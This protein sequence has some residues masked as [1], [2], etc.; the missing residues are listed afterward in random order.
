M[1]DQPA[2]EYALIWTYEIRTA[3]TGRFQK[4]YGP[5][6]SW[7]QLFQ[8]APGFLGTQLLQDESQENRYVTIDRWTSKAAYD[9][10][11]DR[12]NQAYEALDE[13]CTSL[14]LQES[15]NGAFTG[16]TGG[17]TKHGPL[18]ELSLV[19][20]ATMPDTIETE[21]LR[22]RPFG[23][24]DVSEVLSYAQD[25]EWSRYLRTLPRPYGRADA[26]RFI[27]R[28]LL[29]DRAVHPSWAI[30]YEGVVI[31]GINL[32]FNF[33]HRSAELGYSIARSQW[34]HGFCTEAARAVIEHAFSTHEDLIRVHARADDQN[35]ASQR[36]ME[37][38]GMV[39]EGVLRL[40]R[41]E[42]GEAFDE[43]WYSILRSEWAGGARA[44]RGGEGR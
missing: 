27:A 22:L 6:G 42:G 38:V 5:T 26:E 20:S 32:R 28:Q 33:E 24:D 2:V 25:P 4:H 7:A 15:F 8:R 17:S 1:I 3:L 11:R 44:G 16:P 23:L 18:Q 34:N 19:M 30:V 12:F 13:R 10:F 40:N 36:V 39:K 9:S 41:V 21:R 43:A 31:G 14:T 35:G 29:S 37:K